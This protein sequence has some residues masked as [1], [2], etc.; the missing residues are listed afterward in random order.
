MVK[1]ALPTLEKPLILLSYMA[2]LASVEARLLALKRAELQSV[3]K[4]HGVK[5][6]GKSSTIASE[7]AQLMV[8]SGC[9]NLAHTPIQGKENNGVFS[10]SSAAS[11][12]S[13]RGEACCLFCEHWINRYS[14]IHGPAGDMSGRCLDTM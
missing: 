14:N 9:I 6:N 13:G 7:L 11:S 2:D 3:A 8:T 4:R 10:P 12:I 5:A 1:A